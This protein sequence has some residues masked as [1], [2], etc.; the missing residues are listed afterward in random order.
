[1]GFGQNHSSGLIPYYRD[2]ELN[3]FS[4][5]RGETFQLRKIE[6][7]CFEMSIFIKGSWFTCF[8]FYANDIYDNIEEGV[9]RDY[10]N[11]LDSGSSITSSRIVIS[12]MTDYSKIGF[13][14]VNS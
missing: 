12:F 6:T 11:L 10:I 13:S 3:E 14:Y 5:G 1:M 2:L 8:R 9:K 7:E 4:T